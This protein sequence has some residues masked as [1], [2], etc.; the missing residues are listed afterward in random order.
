MRPIACS[1]S[2]QVCASEVVTVTSRISHR[3][4]SFVTGV[5]DTPIIVT[6]PP[7]RVRVTAAS[8]ALPVPAHSTTTAAP[9]VGRRP[10][11]LGRRVSRRGDD[12]GAQ[13]GGERTARRIGLDG[14]HQTG[15]G[16]AGE[17]ESDQTDWA[18]AL[19]D[20]AVSEL[21]GGPA[22]AV[23]GNGRRFELRGDVAVHVVGNGH[24]PPRIE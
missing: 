4:G 10:H 9:S 1:K 2:A 5:D 7:G 11:D 19:D 17:L 8:R 3:P 21:D 24:Q 16:D 15:A 20:H 13:L 6:H 14:D 22:D 12:V 23:H 18:A